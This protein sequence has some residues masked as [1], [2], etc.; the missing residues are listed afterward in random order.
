MWI[1]LISSIVVFTAPTA[2]VQLLRA[3]AAQSPSPVQQ[4]GRST[5]TRSIPAP[6]VSA[7][8]NGLPTPT[9]TP[10]PSSGTGG[11]TLP[12]SLDTKASPTF[13]GLSLTD[14]A[15]SEV[16]MLLVNASGKLT[17]QPI[18]TELDAI[19]NQTLGLNNLILSISGGN[20]I[21][22]PTASGSQA[23]W[24]STTD[25]N[26]FNSK[27]GGYSFSTGLALS[28]STVTNTLATGTGGGQAIHGGT[29]A[30]EHLYIYSTSNE[31]K[32]D[33]Y[34]NPTGGNVGVGTTAPG[35][36][37]AVSGTFQ[38]G[39]TGGFTIDNSGNITSIRDVDYS[40][41]AAQGSSS[42]VLTNNGSGAL[43]W[44][45]LSGGGVTA[46]SLDFSDFKDAMT[47]DA[48]LTID[49]TASNFG[50][51]IDSN[52]LVVDTANN[53]VGV[54][55]A[56]PTT[57]L[58]VNGSAKLGTNGVL[59]LTADN[60]VGTITR[61]LTF[62]STT[63]YDRPWTSYVDYDNRHVAAFGI[64]NTNAGD[65][66]IHKRF[67]LK[68]VADDAGATPNAFLTRFAVD[69]DADLS[70]VL[71]PDNQAV[72]IA[73]DYGNQTTIE[74]R[75]GDQDGSGDT[76][77]GE[78][79]TNLSGTDNTILTL[80][81]KTITA[82]RSATIRMF[83]ETNTTGARRLSLL[84]GDNSTTETFGIDAANGNIDNVNNIYSTGGSIGIGTSSPNARLQ[85]ATTSA[86]INIGDD[87]NTGTY[88]T[89]A[90][91]RTYTGYDGSFAVLQGGTSKGIKLNVN[92]SSFGQG[93]AVTVTS[94]GNLG[95][96][97]TAAGTSATKV[98][99]IGTGTA[100][101]TSIVD[102]VQ[103][104]SEDVAA[105]AE[106]RVRDEAGNVTTLSPHNFSLIP[107]GKSEGLAWS[108][109]SQQ[110][111]E[112]INVDMTK[113]VRLVE[114]LSG[115]KLLFS[116]NL[117]TGED[118]SIVK[119]DNIFKQ[120]SNRLSVIKEAI[121]E[122]SVT[123][124][125]KVRFT[126]LLTFTSKD[127]A[128]K[129]R[130]SAGDYRVQISFSKPTEYEP[131]ITVTPVGAAASYYVT[132]VTK[133]GFVIALEKPLTKDVQFNWLAVQSEAGN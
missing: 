97:V 70:N 108:Y 90:G 66:S 18:S 107:D 68:T 34:I 40:F 83:R 42:T 56:S 82:T 24:L 13:A 20:S 49:A 33:V 52:T 88:A 130:I 27:S 48:N 16:Q 113:V 75:M 84:K 77:I 99:A 114:Q 131:I 93:T 51:N 100:P 111:D 29:G 47:L 8:P 104:Y 67:E 35:S 122:K 115:E 28:G 98:L 6:K 12:Q 105:S 110:G 54:G 132:N 92:N 65:D 94:T 9:P 43:T 64:H 87:S 86:A 25:W 121:F 126:Q 73:N 125:S 62:K 21:T 17:T 118:T 96:G 117:K 72:I 14:L 37:L 112:A 124:L 57:T 44:Q 5:Q 101:S 19:D 71:F 74:Q 109:Y 116:E 3:R 63:A 50:I 106:L 39:N 23:G 123:F 81:A 89:I 2:I 32:G 55:T 120:L 4:T 53:R 85:I 95:L 60:A 45:A 26:N 30:G 7:S 10:T 36:K 69:Y 103:L 127:A 1:I 133:N 15:A 11:V 128:G 61:S 22:F 91:G 79:N 38:A 78:W 119:I 58:D 76:V 59:T 31:S 46:D 102:G 129:A 41:P 80:D